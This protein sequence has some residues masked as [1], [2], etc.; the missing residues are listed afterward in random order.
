MRSVPNPLVEFIASPAGALALA[1]LGAGCL[2]F[3]V[4]A[5][6]ERR[7]ALPLAGRYG[8][9]VA[10]PRGD[11]VFPHGGRNV[12]I[13]RA[14]SVR[15]PWP[16]A[17][18]STRAR[19]AFWIGHRSA[20]SHPLVARLRWPS[21]EVV[22]RDDALRVGAKDRTLLARAADRIAAL[23]T[24]PLF[25]APHAALRVAPR[26]MVTRVGIARRFLAVYAGLPRE[27][28]REP[29]RLAPYL[30]PLVR[31]VEAVEEIAG[32][33]RGPASPE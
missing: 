5:A 3:L 33:I 6:S 7:R 11:V 12:R 28:W 2:A 22:S 15:G 10:W 21:V 23:D 18:I 29:D 9:R 31:L 20:P 30:D 17:V 4:R 1:A 24:G 13:L 8:G 27:I 26:L 14:A 32:G 19:R 16:L 25:G